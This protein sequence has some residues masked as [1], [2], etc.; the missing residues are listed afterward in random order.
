MRGAARGCPR[1]VRRVAAGR[2]ASVACVRHR[3]DA[4]A[5]LQQRYDGLTHE[6]RCMQCQNQSIADSPV[7]L[8]SDLRRD[9]REQLIAGKTDEEIR[10]SMVRATATSSCS[11]RHS[12]PRPPGCGSRRSCCCS[13]APSSPCASCASARRWWRATTA[14]STRT[15]PRDDAR[16]RTDRGIAGRRRRRAAAAAA[17][18][19]REDARPAAGLAAG[20]VLFA[21]LLG[22]AGL[23]A[24]FSNYS[25]VEM[26]DVADTPAAMAAK[27][28]KR[29]AA[30][31]NDL[32][33][34][35]MLG[36]SY[37]TLE[38]FPL[39]VRAYQRADRLANGQNA[40]AIVG[41]GES[42]LAQDFE[43]IARRRRAPVRARAA[44]RAQ[45]SQGAALQRVRG[46]E[47]RRSGE[48]ARALPAHA[49][50][51]SA[52]ADAR[53][54]RKAAASR[55]MRQPTAPASER[56]R[57][58][59]GPKVSV[60]V[61]LAPALARQGARGRAAVRRR[62]R[63]EI[64]RAAV[65]GQAAAR[66]VSGR[67]RVVRRPTP[68]SNRGASRP[69]SSSKWSRAWRSGEHRPRP[70]ATRSDKLAIMWARTDS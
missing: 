54:H 30:E 9:V 15:R 55:S 47:P 64:A 12:R 62:A 67:R 68:C 19:Q 40:E 7:G 20:G 50:A 48:C 60:H 17:V 69:D 61:T 24:A 49:H 18:R 3:R 66:G 46:A 33:G 2:F 45:Q 32:E 26:P 1:R 28:A 27:L 43:Q 58:G 21:L 22:G 37:S 38:Q 39:A 6:L 44:A 4:D 51:E 8:A 65:R 52:A 57:A 34:W 11:G 36:R 42:L 31:P 35:L 5:A 23:Y 29:L 70:A 59:Q 10:D 16:L 14:W 63:S 56:W 41:V 13:S 53:H 25:W